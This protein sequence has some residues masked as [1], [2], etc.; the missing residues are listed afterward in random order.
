MR[1]ARAG[2]ECGTPPREGP[3]VRVLTF[4]SDNEPKPSVRALGTKTTTSF[5]HYSVQAK[6]CLATQGVFCNGETGEKLRE[7]VR[8]R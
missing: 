8:D 4:A 7:H 3:N 6:W 2:P 5:A 1:A